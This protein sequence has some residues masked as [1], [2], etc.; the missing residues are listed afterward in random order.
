[1]KFKI[2]KPIFIFKTNTKYSL[3]LTIELVLPLAI[4]VYIQKMLMNLDTY[5][6][7]TL[8]IIWIQ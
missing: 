2:L 8:I 1:M 7:H 5:K 4:Y 3:C 6:T